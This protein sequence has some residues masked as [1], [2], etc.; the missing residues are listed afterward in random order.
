MNAA[1]KITTIGTM[2]GPALGHPTC[3]SQRP[4]RKEKSLRRRKRRRRR[5]RKRSEA[6]LHFCLITVTF[7]RLETTY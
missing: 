5:S 4:R 2:S 6:Y 1:R 3:H 7:H